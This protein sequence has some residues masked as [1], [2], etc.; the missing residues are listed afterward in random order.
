MSAVLL[1]PNSTPEASHSYNYEVVDGQIVEGPPM[2]AFETS[3]ASDLLILLRMANLPGR[4]VNEML[5]QLK[6]DR[7]LKRR[8]DVAY[9]SHLRWPRERRVPRTEAWDVIPD[10][11]IEVASQSNATEEILIKIRE[12]FQ[13]GCLRVWVVYPTEDQIYVYESPTKVRILTRHD[14]LEDAAVLPGFRLNL[15]DLFEDGT[16]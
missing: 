14:V 6:A 2:G 7:K 11:A 1:S 16:E 10:L 4:A 8:P 12:Y 15:A 5:F 9:V 3:V 13:A